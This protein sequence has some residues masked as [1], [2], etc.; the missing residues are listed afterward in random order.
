[1]TRKRNPDPHPP[2]PEQLAAYADGEL[3]SAERAR[4]ETWLA[5][6]PEAAAEGE[7]LTRLVG[8]WRDNP[9]PE[10]SFAAWAE[11]RARVDAGLGAPFPPAAGRG[12]GRWPVRLA[13]ALLA[14][15][16]L[17]GGV[18]VARGWWLAPRPDVPGPGPVVNGT[19][20]RAN[21]DDPADDDPRA[22]FPVAYA[23]EVNVLSV[24]ARDADAV[25][26][27]PPML[28]EFELAEP[29]DILILAIEPAPDGG[30]EPILQPGRPPMI[31]MVVPEDPED[32]PP[33]P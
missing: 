10:P 13:T 28:G 27:H 5:D 16:A 21:P 17:V 3:D 2:T 29:A 26:L 19:P 14:T 32:D 15:A 20:A 18:L 1:M 7:T 30:A 31:V 12:A 22:P 8:L 23:A 11:V 6:H 24:D 25:V 9:P 4:V 33:P